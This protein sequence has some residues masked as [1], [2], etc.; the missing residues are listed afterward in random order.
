MP[1]SSFNPVRDTIVKAALRL[2]NAYASTGNPAPEQMA[3]ATEACNLMLKS[4]QVE[5]FLWLKQF[6]TL[7]LQPGQATYLLPGANCT[8][9]TIYSTTVSIATSSYPAYNID[10]TDVSD[11]NNAQIIGF[12]LD[13]GSMYWSTVV[14]TIG[15]SVTVVGGLP[16]QASAG[17]AVYFYSTNIG[18]PTRISF[19]AYRNASGFD[20]PLLPM[21]REDYL[22]LT[23]KAT[24]APCNQYYYDPQLEIG[25]LTLW[26]VPDTADRLFISCDRGIYDLINDTD[27]YDVP[28]EWLRL[29]K[30]GLACEIGPEY[31]VPA[32]EMA[33]IEMKYEAMKAAISSYDREIVPSHLILERY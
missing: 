20:R 15:N 33:R 7:F 3:D 9:D 13:D 17:N 32:G 11:I 4:W 6:A 22:R 28:Q 19:A 2:V 5:G 1:T 12:V 21:S 26:P 23:N 16:S 24:Q 27:T 8:I 31:S 30:W 18:R 29:C 14:A 25:Q 10:V